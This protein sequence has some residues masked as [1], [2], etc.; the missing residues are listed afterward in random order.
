MF[1]LFR[2]KLTEA[3]NY[4]IDW[5][6]SSELL[7]SK[8]HHYNR[9]ELMVRSGIIASAAGI[10]FLGAY[11]NNKEKTH[12]SNLTM[13]ILSSLIAFSISH[14]VIVFPL[15]NK[16]YKLNKDCSD[17]VLQIQ[18]KVAE[19]SAQN[20]MEVISYLINTSIDKVFKLSLSDEHH[21]RATETWGLRKNLLTAIKDSL[22]QD[23]N[24]IQ[25]FWYEEKNNM[26]EKLNSPQEES[27]FKLAR[28]F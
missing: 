12:C 22:N 6:R 1:S 16:R 20:D 4:L 10:G 14:T 7:F 15:I 21:D 27:Q 18:G 2:S 25:K 26:L 5:S 3:S 24:A 28:N 19:L 23:Y 13:G 9:N 8:S 11:L 17:L